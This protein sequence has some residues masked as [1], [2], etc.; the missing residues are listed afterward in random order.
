MIILILVSSLPLIASYV[1][2]RAAKYQFSLH[3]FLLALLAG[4]AAFFP[5]LILQDMLSF[6]FHSGR[7]AL[8]F[9]HFVRIALT[10]EISRLILLLIF[11]LISSFFISRTSGQSARQPLSIN[12]IKKATATGFIAGL[13][14]ALLENAVYA[15]A[16]INVLPLRVIFTAAVHA[17]CGSRIGAAAVMLRSN[18]FQAILRV[19]TAVA[20]HG[21]YNMMITMPGFAPLAAILIAVSALVT[22]ILAIRGGWSDDTAKLPADTP[23]DKDNENS[24]G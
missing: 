7:T 23:L 15:A 1:W 4:A 3:R 14:F 24:V 22:A 12:M 9:H 2:F 13:G 11:F 21:I 19:I 18:P 6:S 17:A 16:D 10:E 20:I 8:F 5:A